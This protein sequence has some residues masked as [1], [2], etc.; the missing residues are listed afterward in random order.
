MQDTKSF[1]ILI[2]ELNTITW[3]TSNGIVH[4]HLNLFLMEDI[5]TL[6]SC[7]ACL[8]WSDTIELTTP[9]CEVPIRSTQMIRVWPMVFCFILLS[10]IVYLH[11]KGLPCA[12]LQTMIFKILISCF[13][14]N[15][16]MHVGHQNVAFSISTESSSCWQILPSPLYSAYGN[17]KI[18]PMAAKSIS[19]QIRKF[20]RLSWSS[21]VF[22]SPAP[23]RI[24]TSRLCKIHEISQW[25]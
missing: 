13:Q 20:C 18:M 17:A 23:V 2:C 10:K 8:N 3:F 25:L 16:K 24:D 9:I 11:C 5:K 15:V 4:C 1:Q 6:E 12:G 21:A 22:S 19:T 14:K 7:N